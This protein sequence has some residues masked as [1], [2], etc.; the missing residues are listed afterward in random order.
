MFKVE[1]TGVHTG[2]L[3]VNNQLVQSK[4][5]KKGTIRPGQCRC[6]VI[7]ANPGDAKCNQAKVK[8]NLGIIISGS[9][10]GK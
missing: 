3:L 2:C 5:Q 7:V 6:A 1:G 4:I 8:H 9:S 10:G